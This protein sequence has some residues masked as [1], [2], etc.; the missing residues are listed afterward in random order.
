[1]SLIHYARVLLQASSEQLDEQSRPQVSR[2][3]LPIHCHD[4]TCL[5][6]ATLECRS[7]AKRFPPKAV[8]E[9]EFPCFKQ[10]PI[11]SQYDPIKTLNLFFFLTLFQHCVFEECRRAII[12][13]YCYNIFSQQTFFKNVCFF[14]LEAFRVFQATVT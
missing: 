4:L 2:K 1:M 12:F 13:F 14:Y 11:R 10:E 6:I 7:S 8:N 5:S 3:M 9:K